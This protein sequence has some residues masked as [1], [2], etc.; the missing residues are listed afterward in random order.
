MM[1]TLPSCGH[2]WLAPHEQSSGCALLALYPFPAGDPA[3]L[4][5]VPGHGEN[6]A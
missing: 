1:E 4:S 5:A 2:S 6:L 3:V